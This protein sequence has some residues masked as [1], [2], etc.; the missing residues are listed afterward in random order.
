MSNNNT[1]KSVFTKEDLSV[2]TLLPD[3]LHLSIQEI[4]LSEPG[5]FPLLSQLDHHTKLEVQ[6]I[7]LLEF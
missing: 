6:I 3:S 4:D 5:S 1:F 7:Y 2:L